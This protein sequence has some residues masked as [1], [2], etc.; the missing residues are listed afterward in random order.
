VADAVTAQLRKLDPADARYFAARRAA[1]S[2]TDLSTYHALIAR[3][4]RAYSGVAVGASESVVAPLVHALGLTLLTPATFLR[5][6]SEGTDP[7]TSDLDTIEA[8]IRERRIKV[9]LYNSQN[10]T[11]DVA[12]QVRAA[13]AAGIPV[14]AMTETVSP[15]R[16]TGQQWQS[17]QLRALAA[18]RHRATAR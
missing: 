7:R 5:A 10:A 15:A 4:R 12:R 9:Y 6:I 17:A 18:A 2:A 1:F 13:K 14:T 11:P 16:A 3:I 8:Q